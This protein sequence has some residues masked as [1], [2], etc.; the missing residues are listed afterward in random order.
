MSFYNGESTAADRAD[1]K[2]YPLLRTKISD[3]TAN[4]KENDFFEDI[5]LVRAHKCQDCNNNQLQEEIAGYGNFILDESKLG[6]RK[7]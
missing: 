2:K 5:F 1:G 3:F 4:I 6:L 7:I